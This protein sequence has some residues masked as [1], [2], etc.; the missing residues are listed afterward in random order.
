MTVYRVIILSGNYRLSLPATSSQ[1]VWA[2]EWDVSAPCSRRQ[3]VTSAQATTFPSS[4][5]FTHHLSTDAVEPN[6][7]A[8]SLNKIKINM[9]SKNRLLKVLFFC[10]TTLRQWVTWPD[11]S[12]ACS[13]LTF[14]VRQFVTQTHFTLRF[15][16]ISHLQRRP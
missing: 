7:L 1:P 9:A 5:L 14:T 8:T 3:G 4:S 16:R 12:V 10:D 11:V 6:L 13:V 2:V 15:V